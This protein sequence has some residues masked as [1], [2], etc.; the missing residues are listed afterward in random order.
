[1]R[2]RV[3]SVSDTLLLVVVL[4]LL[5]FIL[6]A[7][8]SFAKLSIVLG[9][10]RNA[11]GAGQLPSGGVVMVLAA[12]LTGYIMLPVA[13]AAGTASAPYWPRIDT[14]APFAADSGKALVGALEQAKEPVRAFLLRN[15][16]ASE[17]GLFVELLKKRVPEADRAE[18]RE[19][20]F[21]VVLP[22]FFITE[23]RE[24]LQLGF[25]LLLPF[26][27]LDLVIAT[28]L[29]SL[30]MQTLPVTTVSLPFKLLLFVTVDGFRTLAET[31]VAGYG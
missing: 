18:I 31:L 11:L 28:I 26:L 12:L 15:S 25:L 1:M 22:A 23:L 4:G 14:H 7:T 6:L 20:D 29:A 9:M 21:G 2:A 3:T 17:L 8:T 16:G 19:R 5:P 27:V 30:G 10:L 24:A 13:R